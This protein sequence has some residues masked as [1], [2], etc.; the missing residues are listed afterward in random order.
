MLVAAAA[1]IEASSLPEHL[2]WLFWGRAIYDPAAKYSFISQAKRP[3]PNSKFHE[4]R[5][6]SC[7]AKISFFIILGLKNLLRLPKKAKALQ[8]RNMLLH[9]PQ[10]PKP[11]IYIALNPIIE[12]VCQCRPADFS[13]IN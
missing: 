13:P 6:A 1:V 2:K 3:A 12:E 4:F 5:S 11:S 10:C 9:Y 7:R 8:P